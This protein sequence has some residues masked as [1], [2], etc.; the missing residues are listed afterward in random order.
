MNNRLEK[1][2]KSV[3]NHSVGE[4]LCYEINYIALIYRAKLLMPKLNKK[5]LN[6]IAFTNINISLNSDIVTM[7]L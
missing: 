7:N 3:N 4:V 5:N 6:A 1:Y 2:F